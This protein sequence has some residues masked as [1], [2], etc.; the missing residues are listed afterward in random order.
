M[1]PVFKNASGTHFLKALFFETAL[2]P[3]RDY[4]L[5]TLKQEDHRGYPSLHRLFVEE[6]DPTEYL[7]AIKY[8]ASW[9]HWKMVK[10]CN[11]FKP[12]YEAMKE[13]LELKIKA[14]ALVDLMKAKEDPRNTVQVNRYL[15]E[16]GWDKEDKR[17]RPSKEK[18]KQE[19][20]KLFKEK[21]IILADWERLSIDG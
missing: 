12:Y 11:W 18:V 13:E 21:D 3:D 5:Y 8:F 14:K 6:N 10:E 17:G 9:T 20:D 2:E 15:I 4:V 16:H 1:T 19:A 7:F